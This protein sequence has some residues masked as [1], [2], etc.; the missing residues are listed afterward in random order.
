MPLSV[1][2]QPAAEPVSTATAKAHLRVDIST[3]DTLIGT[4]I[5]A[6]REMVERHTRRSLIYTGYRYTLDY[7]PGG[8]IHLP[9]LPVVSANASTVFAYAT[10]RIQYVDQAGVTQTMTVST[11]YELDLASNPPRIVQP[12]DVVWPTPKSYKVNAITIDFVSGYGSSA[13]D[14]PAL[15][16]QA[17]LMLVAHWYENREAVGSVGTSVPLAVD[18]ILRIYSAGDYQ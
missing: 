2:V 8:P 15:L 9:R 3:D 4:L 6:A 11:E 17:V 14:V 7:F 16:R 10:P 12:P 18:S 5:T 13:S 1:V